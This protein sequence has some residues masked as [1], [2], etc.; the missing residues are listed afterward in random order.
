MATNST[1]SSMATWASQ[2]FAAT[3]T[4][5]DVEPS[6]SSSPRLDPRRWT[7]VEQPQNPIVQKRI[8][9]KAVALLMFRQHKN[10]PRLWQALDPEIQRDREVALAALEGG[11][12]LPEDANELSDEL[13]QDRDFWMALIQKNA[14]W[15]NV[16]PEDFAGDNE[17]V[18]SISTFQNLEQANTILDIFPEMRRDSSFWLTVVHSKLASVDFL[19]DMASPEILQD[20]YVMLAACKKDYKVYDVLCAPLN[21]DQE[22]VQAAL[23]NTPAA[24]YY[25]PAFVQRMYPELVAKAIQRSP[26]NADWLEYVGDDL[27]SNSHV[28]LAWALIGGEYLQEKFQSHF[29]DDKELFLLIAEHNWS[30]FSHASERLRSNKEYMLR[31]V[32][33]NGILLHDAVGDLSRDFDLAITSFSNTHDLLNSYDGDHNADDARFLNGLSS[34][35]R[36]RLQEHANFQMVLVGMSVGSADRSSLCLLDQGQ[37]TSLIYKRLFADYLGVAVRHELGRLRRASANL[38]AWSTR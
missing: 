37:E 31:A 28:A 13:K 6:T 23:S 12:L 27:W 33:K 10:D 1:K 35:V 22:L 7:S 17:F 24:L 2:L 14:K 8:R 18:R 3:T 21:Q 16:L 32:E 26:Q 30:E 36:Q 25:I 4:P 29:R 9:D 19:A 38:I 5:L 11:S 15:W 34:H 20:K